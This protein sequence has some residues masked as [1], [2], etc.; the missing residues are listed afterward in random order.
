[1]R[2][3]NLIFIFFLLTHFSH[4]M[5][6][7]SK[8]IVCKGGTSEVNGKCFVNCPKNFIPM[9]GIHAAFCE[10]PSYAREGFVLGMPGKTACENK[11][12]S[13]GCVFTWGMWKPKCI[14]HYQ[15]D[16]CCSW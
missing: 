15:P 6:L 14:D 11:Y 1:M 2:L 9:N 16:G 7:K 12:K 13:N 5:N 3:F 4:T 10:A 8:K